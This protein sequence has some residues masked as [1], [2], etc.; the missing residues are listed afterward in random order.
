MKRSLIT[1]MSHY[2]DLGILVRKLGC[3]GGLI[4]T[5]SYS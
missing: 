1:P 2:I 3:I 5:D 4:L